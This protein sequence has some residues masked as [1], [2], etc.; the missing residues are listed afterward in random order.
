MATGGGGAAAASSSYP[1]LIKAYAVPFFLFAVSIF[2]QLVVLPRSFPPSHYDVLGI[3]RFSS[4]EEVKDA[5]EKL[6]SKWNSSAE[7]PSAADFIEIQYAYELLK[8]PLWKRDYDIFGIDEQLDVLNNRR[9]QYAGKSFSQIALP[10]LDARSSDPEDHGL[11]IITSEDF[12]SMFS[13]SKPWLIQIYSLGSS[14]SAQFFN[15][16]KE[17][18]SLLDGVANTGMVEL[19]EVQVATSLAERKP[20]GHFFFRNGLPSLVAFPLGCKTS[21]CL[22]RYEGDLSVD[23]VTDWFATVILGLPRI[24]YHSKETLGKNFLAKSGPHKVKVILFSKTG[25]RATPFVR[26]TAKNYW[27]YASFAFVLWREEDFSFWWNTFEVESAPAIVFLKDPGV[28]P[29]VFHGLFNNSW[30]SDVMEKNKQQ[31]LPQLRS[32][33]S[34]EL[35][36]DARGYSRAGFDTT[37]WYCVILAG[38]LGPELNKMRE[39]M[40]RVGELLSSDGKLSDVDDDQSLLLATA[41]KNKRLTFAWLDGEAQEK[42]CLFYLHSETSYDTCGPRRD[43]SDVPRL[44]IVRYKRNTTQDNVRGKRNAFDDEDADPASQLVARYNGSDETPQIARWIAETISDGETRDLPFFKIKAPDLVP[45]DSDP[46]WSRGAQNILYK[47]VGVKH[48]IYRIKSRIYDHMG[49]PRIGPILLLGALMSFGAVWLMRSQPAHRGQSSQP[50]ESGLEKDETT[51]KRRERR[52]NVL[53]RNVPPSIS[54]I[55]PKDAYQMPMS[56]SDSN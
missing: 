26:Q 37:S 29:V 49:D 30:F 10:L 39:T 36:C 5:Y 13:N 3:K 8:N 7:V 11:P 1:S 47:S 32:T 20:T 43:L 23:A 52:R 55:E 40:R 21:D 41:L 22:V 19:G 14:R 44:F 24:L 35:G 18:A 42:Y 15:S 34:M 4:I 17:I 54:D 25:V 9:E 33:T 53:K 27:S 16:W 6:S 28:K 31:E 46:I 38:R 51:E 45:E 12:R 50:S 48:W 2:Y 56:D